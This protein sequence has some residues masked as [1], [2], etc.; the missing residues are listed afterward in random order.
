MPPNDLSC[1]TCSSLKAKFQCSNCYGHCWWCQG[2]IIQS[3]TQHPFHQ[4]QQWKDGSFENISL[5][6]LGYIFWLEHSS[7]EGNCPEDDDLFGDRQMTIIH[8]NGIFQHCI[9]FFKCPGAKSEHIQ[10]F[11]RWLFS[12]SFNHPQTTFTLVF[13]NIIGLMQWNVK[14]QPRVFSRNW[15][16]SLT[17]LSPMKFWYVLMS[18]PFNQT[19]QLIFEHR[20]D[21]MNWLGW[22]NRWE[23]CRFRNILE[24]CIASP[25]LLAALW[26]FA[27]LVHSL[28]STCH[29]TGSITQ[30]GRLDEQSM[31]MAISMQITSRCADRIWMSHWQMDWDLWQRIRFTKNT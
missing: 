28:E 4:P 3:H 6:D 27:P 16:E 17:M 31:W 13:W 14:P 2:C 7:P 11:D 21:T 15:E 25:P 26:Y 29:P 1:T 9:S 20:T 24:Q 5:C 30:N 23:N 8:V 19:I 18:T 10:L 22:A 12:S